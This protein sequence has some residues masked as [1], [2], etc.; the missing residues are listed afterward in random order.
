MKINAVSFSHE[1]HYAISINMET[2]KLQELHL[3]T[4]DQLQLE[5]TLRNKHFVNSRKV[6]GWYEEV[7]HTKVGAG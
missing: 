5:R 6:V 1:I 4:S 3:H 7:L 2:D